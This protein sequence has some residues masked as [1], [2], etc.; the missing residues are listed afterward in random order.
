METERSS[1]AVNQR[2]LD[3]LRRGR[4]PIAE[5]VI[6]EFVAG[7]LTRREFLRRGTAVGLSMPLLGALLR[8]GGVVSPRMPSSASSSS[9]KAGATIRAGILTP[10]GAINP[11]TSDDPGGSQ[12]IGQ[13]S[14]WLV[15]TDEN[16]NYHPWLASSWSPN[17][18]ATVWTFNLQKSAKFSDG[19][20]MT[21]DDVVYSFQTQTNPKTGGAALSVFS[22][23]LVPDGVV[24]VDDYTVALH[25]EVPDANFVD[26]VS[27]DNFN[28][29]IVPNGYDYS[30]YQSEMLGTGRFVKTG[31][32]PNVG[33]TFIRNPN[34]WG[35]PALPATLEFTFYAGEVPMTA[36]LEA[37]NIDCNGSFSVAT[38]PQLLSGGFNVIAVRESAHRELS[39]RNDLPPFTNK[40]VRQA[41]ALT[42][43]RP[44]IVKA[45][46]KGYAEVGN[47]S[48]FA[49][50]FKATVGPPAVPQRTQNLKLAKELLAKAGVP[51]GFSAPLFTEE[52]EEC[53]EF[54]QIIKSSAAQV[55]VDISLNVETET[56]Y[57][58]SS[59]IGSSDWL[60]GEMSLVAYGARA[61][62]NVFLEAPLQTY[63]KK[64]G[65]G[66]WNAARFNN[67]TYDKLSKDYVA[68]VDLSSQRALAKQIE[69]LLLDETPI[70]YAYFYDGLF[71]TQKNV[72]GVY[73][74]VF[75][76]F[77]WNAWKS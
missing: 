50:I 8:A 77:L 74:T 12:I 4:G 10:A 43:D 63:N 14:E 53:A 27:P 36:G 11:I 5:H 21:A 37:G 9:A 52:Y 24:K 1:D 58:G 65:Q 67:A 13:V 15:F 3:S 23:L 61:V 7:R 26:A 47:D 73:P 20:P 25:L 16:F 6:D 55:G 56:K 18:D 32:T 60:D 48:P 35:T 68:A 70:I 33:A 42:L 44:A 49:S 29:V 69:V 45:L 62:P 40:Y 75:Q 54:A 34:Y 22:G 57:F 66:A 71:A 31:F 39:M 59:T 51:R 30:N 28:M 76:L 2:R 41:L 38:S 46:F 17:A 64:T 72:H 19:T